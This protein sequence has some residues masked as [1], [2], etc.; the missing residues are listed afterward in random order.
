MNNLNLLPVF[1]SHFSLGRSILNLDDSED[2]IDISKP[3]SIFSIARQYKLDKIFLKENSFSGFI[4]FYEGCKKL[5]IQGIFGIKLIMCN[6]SAK[7]DDESRKTES[8]VTIWMKNSDSYKDLLRIYSKSHTENFY[9][10]GRYS[11]NELIENWSDNLILSVDF[12]NGFT[13]R[14]LLENYQCIPNFG[15][16]KPYFEYSLMGLPFDSLIETATNEYVKNNK[17]EKLN[18]HLIFYYKNQDFKQYLLMRCINNRTTFNKPQL[19]HNAFDTFCFQEYCK[20]NDI[21]F[22]N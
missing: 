16:I 2:E 10:Y 15:Q 5:N 6:D 1:T 3:V 22:L 17:Y 4:R 12:Y 20:R 9:Y 21:E 11:W 14:N 8:A 18:T 19:V 7:K 13:A